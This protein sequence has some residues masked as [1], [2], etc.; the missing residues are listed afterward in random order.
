MPED[1]MFLKQLDQVRPV[2]RSLIDSILM[3]EWPS[4]AAVIDFGLDSQKHY[5][6]LYYPIRNAE[7]M[8]R[9]LDEVLGHGERLTALVRSTPSNPHKDVEFHTSWDGI[10][11]RP[12]PPGAMSEPEKLKR[13]MERLSGGRVPRDIDLER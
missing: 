6:A 5:E 4:H 8:P 2:T 1:E 11:G 9:A 12:K 13:T 10:F 7:I 3:D